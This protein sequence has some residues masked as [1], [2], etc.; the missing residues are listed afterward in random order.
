MQ[1]GEE[2]CG[3][4][5]FVHNSFMSRLQHLKKLTSPHLLHWRTSTHLA[6]CFVKKTF[7]QHGDGKI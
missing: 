7:K 4:G 5:N 2:S 3:N 6:M 1:V